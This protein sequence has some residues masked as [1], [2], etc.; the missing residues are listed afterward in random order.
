MILQSCDWD[1]CRVME[2]VEFA[3]YYE[4]DTALPY[5]ENACC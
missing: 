4:D 1:S 5:A 3:L 2:G